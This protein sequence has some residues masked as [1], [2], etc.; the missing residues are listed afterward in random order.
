MLV[1]LLGRKAAV[2]RID[3]IEVSPGHLHIA[4]ESAKRKAKQRDTE[5]EWDM[6]SM[7]GGTTFCITGAPSGRYILIGILL[8]TSLKLEEVVGKVLVPSG[9]VEG[10][11]GSGTNFEA[12]VQNLSKSSVCIGRWLVRK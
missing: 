6:P 12:T 8:N 7:Y 4:R 10:T 1:D 9:L 5:D 3:V 11:V 2:W